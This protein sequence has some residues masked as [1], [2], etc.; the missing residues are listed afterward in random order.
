MTFDPT[1]PVQ[2]FDGRKARIICTDKSGDYPIVALVT[3]TNDSDHIITFTMQGKNIRRLSQNEYDLV[4]IPERKEIPHLK[5]AIAL[6]KRAMALKADQKILDP[7]LMSIPLLAIRVDR[8][9]KLILQLPHMQVGSKNFPY[10]EME[11]VQK[12]QNFFDDNG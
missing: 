5:E 7:S 3:D 11:L 6:R 4:N 8:L 2:T 12:I 10:P 9:E 1:K